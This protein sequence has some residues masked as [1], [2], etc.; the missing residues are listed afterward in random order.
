MKS[1]A[2]K[3]AELAQKMIEFVP[4]DDSQLVRV[5]VGSTQIQCSQKK[6]AYFA[7]KIKSAHRTFPRGA[8]K[9]VSGNRFRFYPKFELGMT[10]A[11]YIA[12]FVALEAHG[13]VL[14]IDMEALGDRPAA[15]YENGAL[16]FDVIEER[17]LEEQAAQDVAQ[18]LADAVA[19]VAIDTAQTTARADE[20]A[21]VAHTQ[22]DTVAETC[23]DT[24]TSGGKTDLCK[25]QDKPD[26]A[27][28]INAGIHPAVADTI[29]RCGIS[30]YG[31][32]A[33]TEIRTKLAVAMGGTP[34]HTNTGHATPRQHSAAAHQ[35]QQVAQVD[36]G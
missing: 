18:V 17:D 3:N 9:R 15:L 25:Y 32:L 7:D 1:A 29:S 14:P 8:Y 23:A 19:A 34:G 11:E 10:T 36:S 24:M 5:C 26:A 4:T 33:Q 16:D 27:T 31:P 12:A 13:N 30:A 21:E 20:L 28:L 2:E 6:T 35:A 22:A